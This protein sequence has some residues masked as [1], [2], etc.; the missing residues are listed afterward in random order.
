MAN[1]DATDWLDIQA[2]NS[3][4]A[5]RFSQL[6]I[7]DLT[8]DS[9]PFVDYI[10]P[11]DKAKFAELSSLRDI[12]IPV[13]LDQTVT[14]VTTPG[15][16]FIPSNLPESAQY[17]FTAVDVF[18]GF[19]HYPSQ[20]ANNALDEQQVKRTVMENVAF[21]M[22][23]T[24]ETLIAV[25]LE[26]RKSQVLGFGLV[27]VS[28]GSSGGTYT[29]ATSI[30]SINKAA[31]QTTMFTS[32]N[33]LMRANKLGGAYRTVVNPA[34]LSVQKTEALQFGAANDKNLQ[35]LGMFGADQMYESHNIAAGS[36]NFN[37]WLIRDGAIAVY[38]NFPA[39][40]RAGTSFAGKTW[41]ISDTELPFT[42]M[43]ANIFVNNE[44]TDATS[45]VGAGTDSNMIM[46]HFQEMAIWH[47]FYIVFRFNED[48]STI[49]NDIVKIKG[50]TT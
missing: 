14:V 34:G 28:Q 7:I 26:N 32:L 31:Q 10:L 24:I 29:F 22:G 19:R 18:S 38:E 4:N 15:F 44:A 49:E 1:L 45:L 16:S 41:S 11:S 20:F 17:S 47:R 25:E 42:R 30:L 43:R 13:I 36:D 50:L 39:D 23:N 46:T 33:E 27:Q 5:K 40:F 35:A 48:L 37:G 8:V 3:T 21:E 9:T 12:Q 6:G 2:S